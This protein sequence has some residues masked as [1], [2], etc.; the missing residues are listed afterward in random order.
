[1]I[2]NI[3]QSAFEPLKISDI[4]KQLSINISRRTLQRR[5][6]QLLKLRKIK[7][8][9]KKSAAHYLALNVVDDLPLS[10]TAKKWLQKINQPLHQRKPVGY[11]RS[12]LEN[13]QPNKTQYLSAASLKHLYSIAKS[14]EEPLEPSTYAKRILHRLL[15]DLSWNSSRLEG[16]TYSLLETERLIEFN[17]VAKGKNVLETQMILNHKDAIEFLVEQIDGQIMDRYT[18]LNLHALLSNNLLTN[19]KAR[20][21]L[22]NIPVG[23]GQTTYHPPALPQ[24]INENFDLIIQKVNKIHHPFE[25]AFFLLVQLPYLQPF[26]DVNKRVSRLAANFPLIKNN[27][28]PLA[29]TDVPTD[30]YISGLLAIYELN[31]IDLLRDVF[32]WAIERSAATYKVVRQTLGEPNVLA[33]KYQTQ[34]REIIRYVVLNDLKKDQLIVEIEKWVKKEIDRADQIRFA[35]LVEQEL[36]SL[37]EGNIAIYRIA[38]SEYQRWKKNT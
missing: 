6:D 31:K 38:Q 25:Q 3:L 35:R 4:E 9:G 19:P 16:N 10:V 27:L 20:G 2:L 13:Y 12:F 24:V 21:H 22:R 36:A 33:M 7:V 1:M 28:S 23:I 11:N 15:I 29:F 5:L 34:L 8:Q 17:A 26:E 32:V 30:L 37:H 18:L 14:S